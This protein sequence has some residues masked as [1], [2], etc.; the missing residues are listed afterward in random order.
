MTI[1]PQRLL[2]KP[3]QTDCAKSPRASN[4]ARLPPDNC[5]CPRRRCPAC[6]AA[7]AA[8]PNPRLLPPHPGCCFAPPEPDHPPSS[9]DRHC[10]QPCSP[11]QNQN[12]PCSRESRD[13]NCAKPSLWEKVA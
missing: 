11:R 10:A 6:P 5:C 3:D 1:D 7:T 9:F 4:E 2:P 13:H 8:A 12:Q